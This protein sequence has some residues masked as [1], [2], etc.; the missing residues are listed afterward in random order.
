M[1]VR[2]LLNA[3][4]DERLIQTS[5][6]SDLETLRVGIDATYW[7]RTIQMLKDP[8]AD[9]IGGAPPCMYETIDR[10]LLMLTRAKIHPVFVF[11]GIAPQLQHQNFQQ[12]VGSQELAAAWTCLAQGPP[13]FDV[14]QVLLVHSKFCRKLSGC[15]PSFTCAGCAASWQLRSEVNIELNFPPNFEGL[16]LGCIDADFC[17]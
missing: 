1:R 15:V 16:V 17:K 14:L 5:S 11:E 13:A 12:Q 6:L 10:E 7:L 2:Q 3:L 9:A 4:Q 8:F